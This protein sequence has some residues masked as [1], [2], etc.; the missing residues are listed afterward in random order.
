MNRRNFLKTGLSGF[1]AGCAYWGT[2]GLSLTHSA[3]VHAAPISFDITA[4]ASLKAVESSVDPVTGLPS[5]RNVHVWEFVDLAGG[6]PGALKAGLKV[7]QGDT[8]TLNF[9]NSLTTHSLRIHIPGIDTRSWPS[10]GPGLTVS[11]QFVAD[12]IGSFLICDR[13]NG[14]LGQAMGLAMPMVV[15]PTDGGSRLVSEISP[16][17]SYISEYTLLLHEIDSRINDAV[18]AGLPYNLSQYNPDYFFVNGLSY[19]DTVYDAAG[20]MDENKLLLLP[21]NEQVA[22]RFI[23]GGLIYYPMHFH[24]YHTNVVL[25]NQT[26]ETHVIEKDTVVLRPSETVDSILPVGSQSGLYPMHTHYVPGVTT[27]GKY[28][29]GALLMMKAV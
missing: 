7:F 3:R 26:R 10:V 29:G 18:E 17:Y 2:T 19:P 8:V 22:I 1:A 11:Y 9:T 25:R 5:S 27:A 24:G 13:E 23:N 6:G 21:L 14:L 28:A 15:Y 20:L 4:L 12:K 16:Q